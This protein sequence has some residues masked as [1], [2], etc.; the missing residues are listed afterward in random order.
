M[1]TAKNLNREKEIAI[2]ALKDEHEKNLAALKNSY[3]EKISPLAAGI[4]QGLEE[5]INDAITPSTINPNMFFK[6]FMYVWNISKFVGILSV[7][8]I[9]DLKLKAWKRQQFIAKKK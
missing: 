1:Q 2:A 5:A 8:V 3:E 6:N 9:K 7:G 4:L